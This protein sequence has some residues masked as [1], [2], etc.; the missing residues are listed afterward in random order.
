MFLDN[1]YKLMS[2]IQIII[3]D[4]ALED[5]S[6]H[7][8]TVKFIGQLDESNVDEKAKIIYDLIAGEPEKGF[9][10]F[11]LEGLEYMNSKSIGYLTDWY[12]KVQEKGGKIVL[13]KARD[14]I[15]DILNIVGLTQII[16]HYTSLEEVKLALSSAA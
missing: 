13:C 14:N 16:E 5:A 2:D 8:K 9:L 12:L 15:L 6:K 10:I 3:E 7:V 1:N 4:L 11:D